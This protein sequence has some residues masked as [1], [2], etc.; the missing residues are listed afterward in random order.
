M[1]LRLFRNATQRLHYAGHELLLDPYFAPKHSRP[2]FAGRS[3]NPLVDLPCP[4]A[5]IM[6][7]AELLIVSHLHSD[8]FD[9][10]AQR[11]LP[12][13]LPVFCQ[14]GDEGAIREH[15]FE[16][17]TPVADSV[18]WNG[19][20]LTRTP[21]QHGSG[22]A[23][24]ADMGQVSGFVFQAPGEPTLYWAGDTI[25]YE[26]V[27]RMIERFRPDVIVTH[28]SGAMWKGNGPI[29]M[30]AAQTLAV[31]Q[32]APESRVVAIHLD[33][34]DHG[35]VTRADLRAQARAAGISDARL[36]I[37]ADGETLEL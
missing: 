23:E 34:L 15:G 6:A 1:R 9:P 24:L 30:D 26:P 7:G 14:P 35:E 25:L 8:H 2:P 12:K 18:T 4:P 32:A 19:V 31:C 10:E 29:V 13:D 36:L 20:T 33:S 22:P 28:S 11:L 37:P 16:R 3:P 17:V 21:G 27:L 5:E